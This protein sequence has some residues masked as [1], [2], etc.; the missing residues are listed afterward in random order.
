MTPD[1]LFHLIRYELRYRIG[2]EAAVTLAALA[3]DFRVSRRAV[4]HCLETRYPDF[5]YV[6]VAGARGVHRPSD[7]DQINRYIQSQRD[8]IVANQRRITNVTIAADRENW[9]KDLDGNYTHHPRQPELQLTQ[10]VLSHE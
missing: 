2:P 6:I 5:G 3:A 10:G 1:T 8:R 7:P 4:E 9:H